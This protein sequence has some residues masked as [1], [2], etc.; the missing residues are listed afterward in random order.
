MSIVREAAPPIP[1]VALTLPLPPCLRFSLLSGTKRLA[2]HT[3]VTGRWRSQ[4]PAT[5]S[6]LS[7]PPVPSPFDH[8]HVRRRL[9]VVVIYL[10]ILLLL[11][12]I[13]PL[14]PPPPLLTILPFF[15]IH[16]LLFACLSF[17]PFPSPFLYLPFV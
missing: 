16:H 11:W 5:L 10:L 12:L 3:K 1:S 8:L 6:P 14:T 13:F 4:G 15:H 9:N 7:H 17:S 2:T